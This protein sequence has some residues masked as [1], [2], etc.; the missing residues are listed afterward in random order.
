MLLERE[1]VDR[2]HQ[3]QL[4]LELARSAGERGAL[5]HRRR[6]R[7]ERRRGLH[8]E[9]RAQR[10]DRRLEL[11]CG[12]SASSISARDWRSRTSPSPRSSSA[13]SLRSVSS[14]SADAR[15]ASA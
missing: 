5:G 12:V 15:A 2:A 13:R 7:V 3:A 8:V 10:V 6:G 4:A 11:A 9:L 14:C 1:R